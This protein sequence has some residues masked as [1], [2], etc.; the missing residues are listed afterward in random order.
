MR[1]SVI[2]VA[3]VL[4]SAC[5]RSGF[6]SIVDAGAVLT[7]GGDPD[8][9]DAASLDATAAA[10][11]TT[12]RLRDD[13]IVTT[14]D[15]QW[16]VGMT[17]PGLTISQGSG[18][19][20]VS[21][22]ASV[23]A[24]SAAEYAQAV[25]GD[26]RGGCLTVQTVAIPNPATLAYT[27]MTLASGASGVGYEVLSGQLYAIYYSMETVAINVRQVAFDPVAHR[28]LRF[29]E[30]AGT[31]TWETSSDGIAFTTFAT[32]TLP[33][34]PASV[35]IHLGAASGNATLNNGGMPAFG[36]VTALVP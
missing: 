16:W 30:R 32:S 3:E 12:L 33:L 23:P 26:M 5:G 18:A 11:G 24:S 19:L 13:F 28:H 17:G 20:T 1:I 29:R 9:I 7:D 6:E 25:A 8:A 10:C 34:S 27:Y 15:P 2:V 14:N 22:A 4:A 36:D 21:F 31:Y 35:T